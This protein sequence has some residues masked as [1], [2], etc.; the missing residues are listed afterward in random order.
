[1]HEFFLPHGSFCLH[2]TRGNSELPDQ[3]PLFFIWR[4]VRRKVKCADGPERVFGE[5]WKNDAELTIA[6]DYFRVEDTSGERF[7]LYRAGDGEH[8]ETGSQGWFLHGIF[9]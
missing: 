7:W 8:G 1:A 2:K 4:G 9:G 3:P 6:R 5:W